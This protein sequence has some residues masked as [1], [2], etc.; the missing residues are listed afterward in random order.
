M[1][2]AVHPTTTAR[3]FRERFVA[4]L[5]L[6]IVLTG[7]GPVG[8][9]PV[10]VAAEPAWP[11]AVEANAAIGNGVE[12]LSPCC[13]Q[14]TVTGDIEARAAAVEEAGFTGVRYAVKFS[15]GQ[16]LDP[17]YAMDPA[18]LD[19]IRAE[20]EAFTARGLAVVLVSNESLDDPDRSGDRLVARWT[21]IAEQY[22]DLPP[23]VYFEI[24]NEPSWAASASFGDDTAV[25][26]DAWNALV[27][28]V[29]PAIR[30]T[31]PQRTIVVSSALW[32][33]PQAI[34][35]LVLPA[36]D[37][38]LI[39][40]FH[41]YNPL[42]FTHQGSWIA[43]S[44]AWIGT[45]WTGTSD[46]V[47]ALQDTMNDAVCWSRDTGVPLFLGEFSSYNAGAF[48]DEDPMR[49][50][51]IMVQ[52]AEAEDISWT[53][54]LL[55]GTFD[56]TTGRMPLEELWDE[57][58]DLWNQSLLDA[59]SRARTEPIEPWAECEQD[60]TQTTTTTISPDTSTTIPTAPSATPA[61]PVTATPRFTG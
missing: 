37:D 26:A 57:E 6:T 10:V 7:L 35:D 58:A 56:P 18:Y 54:F 5:A 36:D 19:Q 17:P 45:T 4:T 40:T 50:N 59:L 24:A 11:S 22:A 60:P 2:R 13:G 43:G 21:Q 8:S 49:W 33:V 25:S 48:T 32:S 23:S 16:S 44:D 1:M 38:H 52:L 41:Q 42:P 51:E 46:E 29:I 30:A 55:N 12:A 39:A 3:T 28:R 31:N 47:A 34:P 27:A 14:D 53:Y 15:R 61:V 9:P 20:I